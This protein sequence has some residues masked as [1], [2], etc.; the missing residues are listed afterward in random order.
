MLTATERKN[1]KNL[2]AMTGEPDNTF[3]YD[4]LLGYMFGLAM[5]PDILVPSEWMPII[6]GGDLPAFDSTEQMQTMTDNLIQVYN[7]LIDDFHNYKLNFPFNI[8][9]LK[10]S[11]FEA[12]YEWISG[13]EEAISLRE[14]LWDP[15]EYPELSDKKK[16]ALYHSLMTI[17]G[18]VDPVEVMD[19]FEEL[20]DELFQEAFSGMDTALNDRE[21]Q[22]Q[23]FLMASLPLAIETFQEHSRTVEKK[24]Q[25]QSSERGFPIPIHSVKVGR[26]DPCPCSSGSD[27]GKKFKKCC[28]DNAGEKKVSLAGT[29]SKKS[30]VIKVDFPQHRKKQAV[31]APLYQLKIELQGA[32]PPIW[33]RIQVPGDITLEHLHGVIQVCMGWTDCHLH[34][35]LIDRICYCLP[36]DDDFR[37]TSRPKNE[38]KYTLQDLEKKIQPR[39]QYIYDFGDDWM[40]QITVEKILPPGDGK[41]TPVLITGRRACPPEDIGGI[42]GYMHLLEVLSD[43]EDEEYEEMVDRLDL[44]FFD[45]AQ[46][47]KEDIAVINA[48]LKELFP[49]VT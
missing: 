46:F 12:L 45:P 30:N 14:E 40:H 21:L 49:Q 3:S 41:T 16:E 24:L 39:F 38:A 42:Y 31:P 10:D 48:S 33:R 18:L 7:S 9:K 28:S 11:Q 13:F 25:R 26:N 4:E 34:Q 44:D 29:S 35:F 17:Q 47:R 1:L 37:Q 32:K 20:P 23:V 5:T 2:L 36:D 8:E 22:I 15:E 6:F 43:P 19:Y 27:S